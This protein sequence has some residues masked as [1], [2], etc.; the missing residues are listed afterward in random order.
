MVNC[1][2]GFAGSVALAAGLE[3][4]RHNTEK[5]DQEKVMVIG[6]HMTPRQPFLSFGERQ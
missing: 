4:V 1:L 3:V 5:P 6:L 2:I